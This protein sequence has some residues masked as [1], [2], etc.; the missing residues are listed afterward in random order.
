MSR[1]PQITKIPIPGASGNVPTGAI[2]FQGDW[3]GLF[4]RGD[5]AIVL[6]TDI[7]RLQGRL[8]DDPDPA[9]ALSLIRLR[10]YAE[11]IQRDVIVR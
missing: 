7:N 8:S 9:I 2:Q 10:Q 1:E 5:D 11:M 3:P 4:V 6:A